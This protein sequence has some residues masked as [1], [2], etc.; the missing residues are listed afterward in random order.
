MKKMIKNLQ[1]L[2]RPTFWLMNYPYDKKW[3]KQLNE[4]MDKF[5]PE[6]DRPS[7]IDGKIAIVKFGG[8]Q[9]WI[10]NYPY[11]YG[12]PYDFYRSVD[13]VRPSRLTILRLRDL[14]TSSQRELE[15]ENSSIKKYMDHV[16]SVL[17]NNN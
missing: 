9:V 2:F 10:E 15:Y 7:S 17:E 3:D 14:V 4:L 6:F 12:T 13:K 11:A 1:F 5:E 16:K 8:C